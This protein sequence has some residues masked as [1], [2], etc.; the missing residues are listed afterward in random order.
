M[1]PPAGQTEKHLS[2]DPERQ[3]EPPTPKASPFLSS[4]PALFILFIFTF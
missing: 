2:E 1:L 3:A 4:L